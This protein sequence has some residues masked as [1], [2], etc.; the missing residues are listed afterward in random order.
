[1]VVVVDWADE[2]LAELVDPEELSLFVDP[3]VDVGDVEVPTF[4]VEAPE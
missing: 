4:E 1:V 3:L 2:E